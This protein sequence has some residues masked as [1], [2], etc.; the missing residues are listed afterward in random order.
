MC[1]LGCIAKVR[2]FTFKFLIP[3]YSIIIL[4]VCIF[5]MSYDYRWVFLCFI[6]VL[7]A[8]PYMW[9]CSYYNIN[10]GRLELVSE[11][12]PLLDNL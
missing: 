8:I 4:A 9:Y 12:S 3:A 6:D 2:C 7:F 5:L 1:S 10:T 11:T